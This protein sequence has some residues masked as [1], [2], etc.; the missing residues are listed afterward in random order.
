MP[1]SC[2]WGCTNHNLKDRNLVFS[3]FPNKE[4]QPDRWKKLVQADPDHPDHALSIFPHRQ[5]STKRNEKKLERYS[6]AKKRRETPE[7]PKKVF[8]AKTKQEYVT[9]AKKKMF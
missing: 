1:K 4:K 8:M 7:P 9:N 3:I 6:N 2:A 5:C